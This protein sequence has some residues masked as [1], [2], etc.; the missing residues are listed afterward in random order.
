MFEVG[1]IVSVDTHHPAGWPPE[2]YNSG[3]RRGTV[4]KLKSV[5]TQSR[6]LLAVEIDGV[7]CQ[8]GN[9]TSYLTLVHP[10]QLEND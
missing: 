8:P 7:F 2:I 5:R 4:V 10:S 9:L 3:I 1:D 6:G